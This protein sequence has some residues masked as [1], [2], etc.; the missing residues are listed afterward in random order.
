M[1]C[2]LCKK[3]LTNPES[4]ALGVGPDCRAKFAASVA[5]A[6]SSIDRI[7]AM[8]Q[9]SN[10]EVSRWLHFANK[11]IAAGRRADVR[12]FLAAAEKVAGSLTTHSEIIE[13]IE[14]CGLT[15]RAVRAVYCDGRPV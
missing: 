11:A 4:L 1:K 5:A 15:D 8:A 10:G 9:L 6:G 2:F 14:Y 13:S 7:E 12:A 3:P